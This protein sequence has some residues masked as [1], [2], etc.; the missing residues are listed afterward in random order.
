VT[1]FD[2]AAVEAFREEVVN[3]VVEQCGIS[4][5]KVRPKVRLREIL[6][7]DSLDIVELILT[8][9]EEFS[10]SGR[11]PPPLGGPND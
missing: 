10:A 5:E 2:K 4:A 11:Q 8:L 7:D 1:F 6:S 9:E 3:L